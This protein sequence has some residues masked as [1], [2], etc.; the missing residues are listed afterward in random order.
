GLHVVRGRSRYRARPVRRWSG[1]STEAGPQ[2]AL[3][4]P[5]RRRQPAAGGTSRLTGE[6][7]G[8]QRAGSRASGSCVGRLTRPGGRRRVLFQP[9]QCD[10]KTDLLLQPAGH[11]L[12]RGERAVLEELVS[13][14]AAAAEG[15]IGAL[16]AAHLNAAS[17]L[18][19]QA[20]ETLRGDYV[21][22]RVPKDVA[23]GET[24]VPRA[25]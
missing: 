17:D 20:A 8:R 4:L 6:R 16:L 14:G 2:S 15:E 1:H 24:A 18:L 19:F 22:Q 21:V 25:G 9:G 12:S 23:Q 13:R 3:V 7:K 11:G 5:R 10:I